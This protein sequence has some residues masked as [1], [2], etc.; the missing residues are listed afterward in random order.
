M[1]RTTNE[2]TAIPST[3]EGET[4]SGPH[5]L[6]GIES[7]LA[8]TESPPGNSGSRI[9]M[10]EQA[11]PTTSTRGYTWTITSPLNEGTNPWVDE[12]ARE[13]S[14]TH[15]PLGSQ[16][17]YMPIGTDPFSHHPQVT[18]FEVAYGLKPT[19]N[20]SDWSPT[21]TR[22]SSSRSSDSRSSDEGFNF[23][24]ETFRSAIQDAGEEPRFYWGAP[25]PLPDQ[26][27]TSSGH[28]P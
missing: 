7:S 3:Q 20:R 25:Y 12:E 1:T 26:P 18:E 19:Q 23:D 4:T 8:P 16:A 28:N 24:E 13:A 21:S 17:G 10:P 5:S 27:P 6:T 22:S 11:G 14:T 2:G 9:L 15:G